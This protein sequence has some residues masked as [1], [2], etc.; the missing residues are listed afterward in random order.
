MTGLN[1]DIERFPPKVQLKNESSLLLLT[2]IGTSIS[3]VPFNDRK[4]SQAISQAFPLS[5]SRKYGLSH[6][7]YIYGIE[8]K[9]DKADSEFHPMAVENQQLQKQVQQ[10]Q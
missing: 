5:Q 4:V 3:K 9:P 10:L 7:Q 8:P 1:V 2:R 6:N